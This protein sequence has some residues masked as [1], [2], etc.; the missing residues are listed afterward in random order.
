MAQAIA[1]GLPQLVVPMSHDQPDNAVRI[2]QLGVGD[3]ILP[4]DY[5]NQRVIEKLNCLMDAAVRDA[6]QRR[7]AN[8]AGCQSLERAS[9]LIEA[10]VTVKTREQPSAVGSC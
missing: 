2:R 9:A 10:L 8:V 3:F 5:T 7:A 1:A 4:K 6:C